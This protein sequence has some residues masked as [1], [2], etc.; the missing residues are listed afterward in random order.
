[1]HMGFKEKALQRGGRK[2]KGK[3]SWALEWLVW[4]K[5]GFWKNPGSNKFQ[6]DPTWSLP[7]SWMTSCD[8]VNLCISYMVSPSLS[9]IARNCHFPGECLLFL[10]TDFVVVIF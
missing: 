6:T 10:H 3:F 4:A 2:F 8:W 9:N 7:E 5:S 1:M